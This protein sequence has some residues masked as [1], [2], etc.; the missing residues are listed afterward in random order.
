MKYFLSVIFFLLIFKITLSQ[1]IENI[2]TQKPFAFSGSI[3]TTSN[4]YHTSDSSSTRDPFT[5]IIAGNFDLSVYGINMPFSFMYSNQNFDYAQPFNR[6]GISPEYKW[7]KLHLGYRTVTHSS[8][9]LANHSFLGAGIELNPGKFRFSS[10]YGRFK[11]KTIPNTVNPLDTLF[12]PTRK[13]YSIKVGVGTDKNYF[14]VIL[15]KIK[16]DTITNL[17]SSTEDYKPAQGN[18][19]LGTQFKFSLARNLSWEAEGAFSIITN[20]LNLNSQL[21]SGNAALEKFNKFFT[22]NESSEYSTAFRSKIQYTLRTFSLG[23]QYRRIEPNYQSFGAYYFNTD[24]ENITMNASARLFKKSLALRGSFGI[25]NDNL[26]KNKARSSKRLITSLTFDYKPGKVFGVNGTYSNFSI[27]QFAGN[28]PLNDTI[29]LYQSNRNFSL[30]P[31]LTF[32]GDGI[33]QMLQLNMT[34]MDLIDHNQFTTENSEVSS[35]M[36]MLNYIRSY[37]ATGLNFNLG[38]NFS[39]LTTVIDEKKMT[40]TSVSAGKMLFKNKLNINLM[41]INNFIKVTSEINNYKGTVFTKGIGLYYRPHPKHMFK[42]NL[43][44]NAVKYPEASLNK[45]Y[46]ESKIIIS[47]VYTFK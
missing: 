23:L 5:Y 19:V 6:F 14:D 7:I 28:L 39:Y 12:S 35:K 43:Y 46:T 26:R 24:V 1:D 31:R 36:L 11:K 29:K 16:D 10:V 17:E 4:F 22:I 13:G 20:N 42:S 45:S 44:F 33:L 41:L 25:Q 3:N 34:Y 2:K 15:L 8:F 38:I 27:N 21:D 47:Y 18:M 30:T 9:T 37:L 40:G 32:T